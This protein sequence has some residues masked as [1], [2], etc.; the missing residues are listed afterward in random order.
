MQI[1]KSNLQD[2]FID[3]IKKSKEKIYLSSPF[4]KENI[5]KLVVENK[6]E[7]VDCKILTKFTIPNIRA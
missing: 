2:I 1:I 4:I 5:A 7:G 6:K 3:L